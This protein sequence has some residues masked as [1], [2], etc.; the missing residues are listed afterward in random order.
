MTETQSATAKE[1]S[2]KNFIT[3][4]KYRKTFKTIE[5]AEDYVRLLGYRNKKTYSEFKK[6]IIFSTK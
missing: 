6:H 1:I 2:L 3:G 4:Y 5:D